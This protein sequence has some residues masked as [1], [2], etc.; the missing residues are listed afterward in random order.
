MEEAIPAKT[1]DY[2]SNFHGKITVF[3]RLILLRSVTHYNSVFEIY[4]WEIEGL[5]NLKKNEI[6]R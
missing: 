1:K 4:N 6:V 3:T 5:L 2:E